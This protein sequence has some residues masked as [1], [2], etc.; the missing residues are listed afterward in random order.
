MFHCDFIINSIL[1]ECV[2]CLCAWFKTVHKLF[3]LCHV[4]T[5]GLVLSWT[6]LGLNLICVANDYGQMLLFSATTR[7]KRGYTSL[8]AEGFYMHNKFVTIRTSVMFNIHF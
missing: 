6:R 4:K 5:V 2:H 1:L 8:I 3:K 7:L